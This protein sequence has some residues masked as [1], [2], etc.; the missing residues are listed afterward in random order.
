M[1]AA[2]MTFTLAITIFLTFSYVSSLTD[3]YM[4][5]EWIKG[6]LNIPSLNKELTSENVSFKKGCMTWKH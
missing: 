2:V 4:F 6:V 3:L 5:I 1:L